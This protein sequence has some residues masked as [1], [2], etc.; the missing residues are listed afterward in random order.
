LASLSRVGRGNF[1]PTPHRTVPEPLSSYGSCQ[2]FSH[3]LTTSS[4]HGEKLAPPNLLVGSFISVSWPIPF[5]PCSLQELHHYYGMVRPYCMHRYFPP[6]LVLSLSFSLAI[7]TT[8]S[9]VPH[10]SLDQVHATSMPGAAQAINRLPLDSSWKLERPPVL[11]PSN[12]FR[13]CGK[14]ASE[15]FYTCLEAFCIVVFDDCLPS[16]EQRAPR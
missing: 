3:G 9:H 12:S 8:G 14:E 10:K 11:T 7:E 1:T 15:G 6:S 2:P 5:A 13:G 16:I 4:R